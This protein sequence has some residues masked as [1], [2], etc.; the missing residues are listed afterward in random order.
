VDCSVD[1]ICHFVQEEDGLVMIEGINHAI[2]A[3]RVDTL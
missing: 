2:K 3:Y 1:L